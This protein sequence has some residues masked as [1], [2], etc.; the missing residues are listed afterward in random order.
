MN[1]N[2]PAFVALLNRRR[3]GDSITG[4]GGGGDE[5]ALPANAMT[6][7]GL[8]DD[9]QSQSQNTTSVWPYVYADE[10]ATAPG[11]LIHLTA[12]WN[13]TDGWAYTVFDNTTATGGL[14][15]NGATGIATNGIEQVVTPG[16]IQMTTLGD[17]STG[18]LIDQIAT[19]AKGTGFNECDSGVLNI[20]MTPFVECSDG[21]LFTDGLAQSQSWA[22]SAPCPP[23]DRPDFSVISFGGGWVDNGA[24]YDLTVQANGT[25]N[26]SID[27]YWVTLMVDEE[28]SGGIDIVEDLTGA[29]TYLATTTVGNGQGHVQFGKLLTLPELVAGFNFS[30]HIP[31]IKDYSQCD[32]NSYPNWKVYAYPVVDCAA[33]GVRYLEILNWNN[34]PAMYAEGINEPLC[35]TPPTPHHGRWVAENCEGVQIKI[36]FPSGA[37]V[38]VG[39]PVRYNDPAGSGATLCTTTVGEDW[40]GTA[41]LTLSASGYSLGGGA[42]DCNTCLTYGEL[43]TVTTSHSGQWYSQP[44]GGYHSD[45]SFNIDSAIGPAVQLVI[46]SKLEGRPAADSV[47]KIY[48][49]TNNPNG[50]YQTAG[51]IAH[52]YS[53]DG[54]FTN[55]DEQLT[56][57]LRVD[58]GAVSGGSWSTVSNTFGPWQTITIDHDSAGHQCP[59]SG[60]NNL[61]ATDCQG[62]SVVLT[63]SSGYGYTAGD[64]VDY[65]L[66]DGT[67]PLCAEITGT[68]SASADG[69]LYGGSY[70]DCDDCLSQNGLALYEVTD[71]N[72][73]SVAV[74]DD[75]GYNAPSVGDVVEW[76]DTNS[77][78]N[79]GTITAALSSG[80]SVGSVGY[81]YSTCSEC[82]ST[83]GTGGGGSTFQTWGVA[84][85]NSDTVV[86]VSDEYYYASG[87]GDYLAYYDN[88]G[89]YYCGE[90]IT[91]EGMQSQQTLY[92]DFGGFT[93]CAEC[94]SYYG[95]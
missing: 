71:C 72:D 16:D 74:L 31:A 87:V 93:D 27:G 40:T 78:T 59:P 68:T 44:V 34:Q 65:Y 84:T 1:L 13:N 28:A 46:E 47:V 39:I 21:T 89:N 2:N 26:N 17:I 54:C 75:S 35:W 10:A 43:G 79:C 18:L 56:Y 60:G 69:D 67:G 51:Y 45:P 4:I 64:F 62:G 9:W 12:S 23:C 85:C 57:R 20:R 81:S 11:V 50:T 82:N 77:N 6:F 33:D 66:N 73:G 8:G 3:D 19:A 22:M 92:A 24:G 91:D 94:I 37:D 83:N 70:S 53:G 14:G 41:D 15:I 7:V 5:C 61:T 76:Y 58:C 55:A 63:D 29:Q 80:T 30:D 42:C 38:G 49:Q 88:N 95:L 90:I 52:L 48:G 36:Q 32:S 25:E 86:M